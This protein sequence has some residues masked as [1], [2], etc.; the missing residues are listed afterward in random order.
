MVGITAYTAIYMPTLRHRAKELWGI[1]LHL[2]DN[3]YRQPR[4]QTLQIALL[5]V[6]GRPSLNSGGNH[7]ALLRVSLAPTESSH[8]TPAGYRSGPAPGLTQRL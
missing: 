1:L 3:E 5:D 8:L 7:P 6:Y 4:L 2:L